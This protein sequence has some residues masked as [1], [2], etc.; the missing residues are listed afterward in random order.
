MFTGIVTAIGKVEAARAAAGGLRLRVRGEPARALVVGGSI[1]VEGVCLTAVIVAGDVFEADLSGET[2]AKTTLGA[3]RPGDSVN[4]ELP[5]AAGAPLGG[6][7]V[8][9]H[10]DG[11]GAI[12]R[13]APAGEGFELAVAIRPKL[14]K[15]IVPKGSVAVAGISLTA[16]AVNADGFSVAVI[17]HTFEST[18]LKHRRPGDGVNVEVDI[19]AKYVERF[20]KG[21]D[22]DLTPER[23]KELGY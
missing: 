15:Y 18:T 11:I 8:Q 14:A 12:K 6:H 10:T 9:G 20:V 5:L 23:L 17:P 4:L 1:A 13:L 21:R 3:I 7:L 2:V 22:G 19:I 16:T